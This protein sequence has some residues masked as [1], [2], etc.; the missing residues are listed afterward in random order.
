ME[1]KKVSLVCL[2]RGKHNA[3]WISEKK[4]HCTICDQVFDWSE[5]NQLNS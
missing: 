4:F 2:V 1:N 3:D 5:L